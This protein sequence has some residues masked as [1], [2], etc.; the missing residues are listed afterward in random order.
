VSERH[1]RAVRAIQ[2]LLGQ[3]SLTEL[4]R[5][6]DGRTEARGNASGQARVERDYEG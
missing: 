3:Q 5:G 2:T 6:F 4:R 1:E